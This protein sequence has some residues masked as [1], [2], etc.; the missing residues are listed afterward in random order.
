MVAIQVVSDL[1][2]ESPKA[3]D[4]FEIPTRAPY[5]AL[6]GD[7]GYAKDETE[8]LSFLKAHLSRFRVV[9]LVLGNHEPW[10][11]TWDAARATFKQFE[12]AIREERQRDPGLGEFVLLDKTRYDIDDAER[13]GVA[14]LGCTLFTRVPA[15]SLE[16]VSFGMHDFYYIENWTVEQH[17]QRF[18]EELQW[19]NEEVAK[20]QGAG[21]KCIIFSHYSPTLDQRAADPR[22]VNSAIQTGFATEL[23]GESCF[24]SSAV[25]LWAFGHTHFNCDFVDEGT[26]TRVLANQR[27][28]Y[29]NQ[30]AEFEAGKTIQL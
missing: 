7:I 4:L 28:A 10:H 18:E 1:H 23:R 5:L 11:L 8:Y 27:G 13:E 2:L 30:S 20:V 29:F 15:A 14:I 22:H 25:K 3:Y 24:G 6:L 19:L 12:R 9:F 21:K 17:T 16:A 26:D